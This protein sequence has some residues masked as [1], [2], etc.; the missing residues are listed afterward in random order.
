MDANSRTKKIALKFDR[1]DSR[2]NAG[3]FARIKLNTRVYENVVTVPTEALVQ[4]RGISGVYTVIGDR[5]VFKEISTGVSIDGQV[6]ITSG[7]SKGEAVVTQGQQLLSE[8]ARV[9]VIQTAAPR[10]SEA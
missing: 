10:G 4:S 7:L 9:R 5:A 2:V 6:E 3:M 1:A 8:G